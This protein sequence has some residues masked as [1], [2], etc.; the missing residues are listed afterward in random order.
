[1]RKVTTRGPRGKRPTSDLKK[2]AALLKQ[3]SLYSSV[4]FTAA[5]N[6]PGRW[7]GEAFFAVQNARDALGLLSPGE[8]RIV[9]QQASPARGR[10]TPGA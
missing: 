7:V 1:M 8:A 3:A 5:P 4:A 2:V 10:G 9:P 6:G